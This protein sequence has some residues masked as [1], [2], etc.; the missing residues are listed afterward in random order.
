M[1]LE[2]PATA[3]LQLL[4]SLLLLLPV[5]KDLWVQKTSR[6]H[7]LSQKRLRLTQARWYQ[8]LRKLLLYNEEG[9]RRRGTAHHLEQTGE[10]WVETRREPHFPSKPW[11]EEKKERQSANKRH[12]WVNTGNSTQLNHFA[13][14]FLWLNK[15]CSCT[16]TRALLPNRLYIFR[17]LNGTLKLKPEQDQYKF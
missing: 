13:W 15:N 8:R 1:H 16:C 2:H 11:R 7:G 4:L 14:T 9:K 3:M 10:G 6:E 12:G 5:Q 17:L